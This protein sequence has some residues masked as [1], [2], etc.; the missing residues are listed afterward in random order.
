M[1]EE[2]RAQCPEHHLVP[3]PVGVELDFLGVGVADDRLQQGHPHAPE[4]PEA[5]GPVVIGSILRGLCPQVLEGGIAGHHEPDVRDVAHGA[6]HRQW[7]RGG[8][9][10]HP[11]RVA[12]I[13]RGQHVAGHDV[14]HV[15]LQQRRDR[16]QSADGHV[17]AFESA[18]GVPGVVPEVCQAH[19]QNECPGLDEQRPPSN[20]HHGRPEVAPQAHQ[21]HSDQKD[22][23]GRADAEVIGH[24]PAEPVGQAVVAAAATHPPEPFDGGAQL[25]G[26]ADQAGQQD[27]DREECA[28]HDP[29]HGQ[30]AALGRLRW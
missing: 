7:I 19:L 10:R 29:S 11:D 12:R 14:D 15:D 6:V 27:V 5:P 25:A 21:Q 23:D 3:A 28:D 17:Q 22:R 4:Q 1:P 24:E 16:Q 30:V 13:D 20:P 9:Q 18:Q 2:P 8:V 26:A